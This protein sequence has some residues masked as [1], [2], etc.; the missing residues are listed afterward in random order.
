MKRER[1][2]K[3]DEGGDGEPAKK[4]R[5]GGKKGKAKRRRDAPGDPEEESSSLKLSAFHTLLKRKASEP[6]RAKEID[7]EIEKLG[8]LKEY[9]RLSL[10]GEVAGKFESS[11]WVVAEIRKRFQSDTRL[12]LL[13]VG[14]IRH[15]Y[16]AQDARLA[17]KNITLEA[18]S[19]DLVSEDPLV[20]KEDF[21]NFAQRKNLWGKFD[22]VVMS[23]V[24]NFVA[25]PQERGRMLQ[26]ASRLLKRGGFMFLVLPNAAIANSRYLKFKLLARILSRVGLPIAE[27]GAAHRVTEKL[28]FATCQRG[29]EVRGV[30]GFEAQALY[31]RALC[32][33]GDTRNNFCILL[34]RK[35]EEPQFPLESAEVAP[36]EPK[37]NSTNQRKRN[38]RKK[39][40]EAKEREKEAKLLEKVHEDVEE[41]V[42]DDDDGD[43]DGDDDKGQ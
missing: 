14:A 4:E 43:D 32:R 40:K 21:F 11:D 24:L 18:T 33:G 29:E 34:P 3:P 23:L 25:S 20:V 6:G 37:P 16:P 12:K 7:A 42:D 15:R 17:S 27:N 5:K 41:L 38:R 30:N 36:A 8:G 35:D 31:K 19:I 9:Q 28:F 13:D 26:M 1:K 2:E 22:V 39:M 10:G